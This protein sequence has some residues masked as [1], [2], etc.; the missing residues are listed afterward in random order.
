MK[1]KPPPTNFRYQHAVPV[2][3]SNLRHCLKA[4]YHSGIGGGSR[5]TKTRLGCGAS[6]QATEETLHLAYIHKPETAARSNARAPRLCYRCY[7]DSAPL[8]PPTHLRACGAHL[9]P[10][11]ASKAL[12]RLVTCDKSDSFDWGPD[13]HAVVLHLHGVSSFA[14]HPSLQNPTAGWRNLALPPLRQLVPCAGFRR[15][16]WVSNDQPVCA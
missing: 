10:G 7:L 9:L 14:Q 6:L 12:L 1:G 16:L 3:S 8:L 2:K 4:S 15:P 5:F 13:L 11:R